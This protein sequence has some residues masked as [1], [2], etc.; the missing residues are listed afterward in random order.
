MVY[1]FIKSHLDYYNS[2]YLGLILSVRKCWCPF[3]QE[4]VGDNTLLLPWL[5]STGCLCILEFILKV[6]CLFWKFYTAL[7]ALFSRASSPLHTCQSSWPNCSKSFP[8]P[9]WSFEDTGPSLIVPPS[10]GT[11]CLSIFD[12]SLH[13]AFLKP[14]WKLIFTH[15]PSTPLILDFYKLLLVLIL[16]I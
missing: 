2:F 11:T 8:V 9:N 14:A 3:Y 15:W 5:L 4:H 10:Y 12:R 13:C 16:S 1:P 7:P 6:F